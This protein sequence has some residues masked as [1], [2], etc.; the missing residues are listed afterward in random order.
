MWY[1]YLLDNFGLASKTGIDLGDE[2]AGDVRWYND[3]PPK[4]T[5]YPAYKDTQ[6][7][8]QGLSITPL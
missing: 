8:G 3:A 1:Q 2:V 6:A 7:Y 5:W 4:P